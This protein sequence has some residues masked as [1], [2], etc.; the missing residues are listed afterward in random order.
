MVVHGQYPYPENKKA[1][2][3]RYLGLS[4]GG[5][6]GNLTNDLSH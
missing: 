6:G 4:F 1:L 2:S 5:D 3:I